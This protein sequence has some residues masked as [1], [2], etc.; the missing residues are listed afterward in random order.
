MSSL[1]LLCPLLALVFALS[2]FADDKPEPEKAAKDK[3]QAAD[4][5]VTAGTLAG[6]VIDWDVSDKV[7]TVNVKLSVPD[8]IDQG[9][10]NAIQAKQAELLRLQASPPPRNANEYRDRVTKLANLNRE[11]QQN[12]AKLYKVKQV[13]QRFILL[14]AD[15][16][17]VR[18]MELPPTFDDKG[19][20][21]KRTAKE[22]QELRGKD[23]RLPGYKAEFD[24]IK[25]DETVKVVLSRKRDATAETTEK[26]KPEQKSDTPAEKDPP[27]RLDKS[28]QATLVV[29]GAEE[30]KK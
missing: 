29:I 1:R 9:A 23:P 8:G 17:A 24:D 5:L 18:Q 22:K 7:L 2:V 25:V 3:K 15:N 27:I 13:D 6:K 12:Q 16:A 21:I 20:P 28:L 30:P 19:F 4:K 14:V 11:I 26:G 10:A